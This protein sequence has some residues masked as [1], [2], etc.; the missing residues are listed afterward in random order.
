MAK[1]DPAQRA[2]NELWAM[3]D[4]ERTEEGVASLR[5]LLA[6]RSNHVVGRA[7]ALAQQWEVEELVPDLVEAF[8]RFMANPVKTDPTCAAKKPIIEALTALGHNDPEIYLQGVHH[9]QI[10]PMYEGD[11]ARRWKP[12]LK[13]RVWEDFPRR[14]GDDTA[15]DLRGISGDA[16]LGCRYGDAYQEMATLLM[17]SDSRTRRIAM[18]SLGGTASDRSELL[19]R[20]ALLAGD[21]EIDI[22]SLGLQGLMAIAP[23]RSLEFVAE[24]LDSG[25]PVIA[26]GAALAIGEARLPESFSTLRRAW[27]SHGGPDEF[28]LMLPMALTRDDEAVDFLIAVVE[29]KPTPHAAAAIEAL[30]IYSGDEERAKRVAAA[31]DGRGGTPMKRAFVQ[32]FGER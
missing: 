31:V 12:S 11:D 6:H 14:G 25:E 32:H 18:E 1:N 30:A 17:D 21:P 9:V 7:A 23:E 15:A 5:K 22:M 28:A 3:E 29:E 16:L 26:E 27:D 8:S 20:M 4:S 13:R 19:I 2:L 10:E 24:F